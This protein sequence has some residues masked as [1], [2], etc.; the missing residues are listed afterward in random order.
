MSKLT[1]D[2][3]YGKNVEVPH[4]DPLVIMRRIE[5]LNEN[6]EELMEVQYLARDW[7]RVN[8]IIKSIRFW[9]TFDGK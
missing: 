8:S 3:L 7:S 1:D 5:L 9:E 6:L 4:I 2:Y